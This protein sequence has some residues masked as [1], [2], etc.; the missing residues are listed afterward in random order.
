MVLDEGTFR[1]ST[2]T[3][4]HFS[5]DK[6][7]HKGEGIFSTGCAAHEGIGNAAKTATFILVLVNELNAWSIDN[8]ELSIEIFHSCTVFSGSLLYFN[9]IC[10]AK[11]VALEH[12]CSD[13]GTG[14]LFVSPLGGFSE[15][16]RRRW[17]PIVWQQESGWAWLL[18]ILDRALRVKMTIFKW[19]GWRLGK[20]V[21]NLDSFLCLLR[22]PIT[23]VH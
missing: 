18:I 13:V 23:K 2:P 20:H 1:T 6:V 3:F 11:I 4:R 10:E 12:L 8:F 17:K 16:V 19:L 15:L 9:L 5:F 7:F 14:V 22:R 21:V